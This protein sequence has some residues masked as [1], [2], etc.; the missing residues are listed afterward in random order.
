MKKYNILKGIFIVLIVFLLVIIGL[1]FLYKYD[2]KYIYKFIRVSNGILIIDNDIF[3]KG[4]FVFLIDDWE[5]YNYKIFKL[6]DFI[7]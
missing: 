7:E 2:N 5:F 1:N 4:K 3:I 6:N